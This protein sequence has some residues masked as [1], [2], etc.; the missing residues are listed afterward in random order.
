MERFALCALLLYYLTQ[1]PQFR[2]M[3]FMKGYGV[4][5]AMVIFVGPVFFTLLKSTLKYGMTGG[6]LVASGII[7]SDILCVVL[8]SFGAIPF[9]KNPSNQL[10]LAIA[11]CFILFGLGLKYLF[12]PA[13]DTQS[14]EL[15]GAARYTTFFAKGFVV[16][17]ANPF[18]FLVWIGV[19]GIARAEYGVTL[20]LLLFLSAALLG[21]FTTDLLKVIFADKLKPFIRPDFLTHLYRVIGIALLAFGIR[22]LW[23]ALSFF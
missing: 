15:P 11:G 4:G 1:F 17:F 3:A 5:L 16:N 2:C 14:G 21:I 8:C 19:I 13:V 18:V 23:Y 20:N 6:L 22:M 12:F 10:G 7:F 9:F